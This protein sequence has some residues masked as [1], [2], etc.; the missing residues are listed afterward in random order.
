M[1]HIVKILES[2]FITHDVKYFKVQRPK[3]Y[4]FIPGQATEVS[5]NKP[6][7]EEQKRAF[8]FTNL[9][10]KRHLEFMVKI[11]RDHPGVT[12]ELGKTNSDA[13]L[14][15][16]DVFGAIHYQGPG[17]FLAA[18]SGIT[19]FIAIFR[20]LHKKKQ[21]KGNRLI[22]SNKTVEDIILGP[23]LLLMLKTDFIN[24]ITRQN[25]IGF[26][27]HRIDRRFL[28]GQIADFNQ[29]F[30]VCG[31]ESFVKSVTRDLLELGVTPNSLVVEE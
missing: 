17:V 26:I 9:T 8:T 15:I 20:D 3:G 24:V 6:G 14:I 23:E 1:K 30:Y 28:I 11:Y 18:G 31:P 21:L 10:S 22:Y 25:T 2:Y 13:E 12:K 16:H 4:K 5:I 27:G 19:P 7:W 29:H